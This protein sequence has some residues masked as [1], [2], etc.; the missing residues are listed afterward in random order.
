MRKSFEVPILL[1]IHVSTVSTADYFNLRKQ[2]TSK[3]MN[4][5]KENPNMIK[6]IQLAR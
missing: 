1:K 3:I 2:K 5:Q 4:N 6:H